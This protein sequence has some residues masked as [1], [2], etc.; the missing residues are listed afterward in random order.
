HRS[1]DRGC[2]FYKAIA[3]VVQT[4]CNL[5]RG[6]VSRVKGQHLLQDAFG[7]I[8]SIRSSMRRSGPRPHPESRA[9]F[10][11][12]H[13]VL[14]FLNTRMR[15]NGQLVDLLQREEDVLRWLE[16][17]GFP[18]A[19]IRPDTA[20]MT[21]VDAARTLRESIR[22]LVEKRRAGR[23]GDPSVLNRFLAQA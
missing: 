15:V 19:R 5:R 17:A 16:R 13:P 8:P 10:L 14:D 18:V 1:L 22:S 20:P 12:G 6:N 11:A 7:S 3:G 21:L 9:L 23:R 2:S 4:F